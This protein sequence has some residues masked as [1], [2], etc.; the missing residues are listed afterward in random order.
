MDPLPDVFPSLFQ[1]PD[2]WPK[3]LDWPLPPAPLGPGQDSG[4]FKGAKFPENDWE[5]PLPVV[6]GILL[7][8]GDLKRSHEV[9]QGLSDHDG[10]YWHGLMHRR[11]PDYANAAYWF[12]RVGNHPIHEPLGRVLQEV[13]WESGEVAKWSKEISSWDMFWMN[14][15]CQRARGN[16]TSSLIKDL[17]ALQWAE[18]R[19][20][21]DFSAGEKQVI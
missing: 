6:S 12:R 3:N 2:Y 1:K 10:A 20:L 14:D 21:L 19:L 9:S 4:G 16:K 17:E 13:K 7:W 15:L 11:E 18:Y 5:L 8:L